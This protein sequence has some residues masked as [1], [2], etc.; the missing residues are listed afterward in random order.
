MKNIFS[1][2]SESYKAFKEN[3]KVY[4]LTR[5]IISIVLTVVVL[6]L[7]Y[8]TIKD[9]N[10]SLI[11]HITIDWKYFLI[12]IPVFAINPVFKSLCAS[13]GYAKGEVSF[14]DALNVTVI[15]NG[16]NLVLPFK[17]GEGIRLSFYPEGMP[18]KKRFRFFGTGVI[19]DGV[20]LFSFLFLCGILQFS[21]N[22]YITDTLTFL[23]FWVPA[24]IALLLVLM[25]AVLVLLI[26][27]KS[28]SV[29]KTMLSSSGWYISLITSALCWL[30]TFA[31]IILV[32]MAFSNLDFV[33]CFKLAVSVI[34]FINLAILIPST[35]GQLGIFELAVVLA[36]LAEGLTKEQGLQ[37]GLLVHLLYYV[38][39]IPFSYILYLISGKKKLKAA[40][41]AEA[42]KEE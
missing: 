1:S 24:I 33:T 38:V 29:V 6:I 21:Q 17:L 11:K 30:S 9:M 23:D 18:L 41:D 14:K 2:V 27:K 7:S 37:A 4:N 10:F 31:S 16:L 19:F 20:M 32:L 3:K 36:F 22:N 42:Q 8:L 34:C 39:L 26:F 5:L 28:R 35:P 15:G 25:L 13:M 40:K 12:A